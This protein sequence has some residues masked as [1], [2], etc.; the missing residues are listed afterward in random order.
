M[1][2]NLLK[3]LKQLKSLW[4][5][6]TW[7]DALVLRTFQVQLRALLKQMALRALRSWAM[8]AMRS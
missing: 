2:R 4:S 7:Q 6:G 8:R 1:L 3:L 5:V